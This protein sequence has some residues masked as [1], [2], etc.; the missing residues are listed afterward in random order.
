[1]ERI[2][3]NMAIGVMIVMGIAAY[4]GEEHK[5]EKEML[6]IRIKAGNCDYPGK[7]GDRV[8]ELMN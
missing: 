6:E 7:I 2:L 3:I 5:H 8:K 1:M 4:I